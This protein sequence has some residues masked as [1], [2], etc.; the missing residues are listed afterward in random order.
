M[1]G[2]FLDKATSLL[3]KSFLIAYWFPVF[4]SAS[5]AVLIG[6]W[7]LGWKTVLNLWQQDWMVKGQ[8][9][10]LSGQ[11]MVL[12]GAL[13]LITVLAYILMPF[14]RPIVRLYE[15]YWSLGLQRWVT[16]LPVFGERK[17][18]RKMSDQRDRAEIGKDWLV[19]NHFHVQ[20]FYGFPSM[21]DRIM[22]TR[23]GNTL[24]A[25]E[26]YSYA[27]YGMDCAFWWPRLWP[28][29]P[30]ALKKEVEESVTPMVALL[31]FSSLIAIV[32]VL[33]SVCLGRTGL[34]KQGIL[35]ILA[36]LALAVISY[37]SAVAQAQDYGERIRSAVDL[38]R[39]DLLKAL[40]QTLPTTLED[41]IKLWEKLMLWLYNRDR[42][43]VADIKYNLKSS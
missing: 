21:Q 27:S 14:T 31:N 12:V 40:H 4:M 15:G 36:G 26:D 32:S 25:S 43:A 37:R 29:L 19:Y 24:R 30:E 39:F 20:L 28:L 1:L 11:I 7:V 18:W 13:I 3:D 41:E 17:I 9:G 5:I 35:V 42:G 23:L 16:D 33:S 8:E 2:S 38:Y 6:A 10:G 34:G 22:P